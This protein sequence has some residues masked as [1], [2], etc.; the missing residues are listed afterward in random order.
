M[1]IITGRD[2]YVNGVGCTT[3]WMVNRSAAISRYAASCSG[4]GTNV[5]RGN[6]NVTGSMSGIGGN[7]LV[8]PGTTVAFKGVIDNTFGSNKVLDGSIYIQSLSLQMP[9]ESGGN[10]TWTA[11]FGVQGD[12][13]EG[14]TGAADSTYILHEGASQIT[15]AVLYDGGTPYT[16][17]GFRQANFTINAPEKTYIINGLTHRLAG[18][19]EADISIDVYDD[20]YNNAKFA[21]NVVD[22]LSLYVDASTFWLFE[23][24]RFGDVSN[25]TVDRAGQAVVSY[26]I[27]GMWTAANGGVE[28]SIVRPGGAFLFGS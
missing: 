25:F 4:Y 16:I 23:W 24:I 18:N 20:D 19:L 1:S 9:K 5:N 17:P 27:N 2:G 11:N 13:T 8:T 21:P 12:L 14:T 3:S 6:L 10:L 7:P 28:G 15:D 22:K 26:T